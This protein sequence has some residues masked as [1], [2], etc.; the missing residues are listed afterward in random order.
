LKDGV[1]TDNPIIGWKFKFLEFDG[2]RVLE[3]FTDDIDLIID[4]YELEEGD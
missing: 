3:L 1:I 4:E 2:K